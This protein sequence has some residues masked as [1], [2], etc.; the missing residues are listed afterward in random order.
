MELFSDP[1]KVDYYLET[2]SSP[3][4]QVLQELTRHT[5]LKEVHPQMLSGKVLGG[6]L[7]LF[8]K[9]ISPDRILE[10]GT[11]TG[12]SAIC[13]ARGLR[14]DGKLITIEV[15]EELRSTAL[16]YFKQAG[17]EDRIQ[18]IN[19]PALEVI[20]GLKETFDLV[21]LDAN[22]EDYLAYY[23]LALEKLAQGG[24]MLV[25]NVLWSGKV[26]EENHSDT[27]TRSLHQF[28]Q[29]VTQDVRVENLLLPIRDGLMVIKKL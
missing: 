17:L 21:F 8:S 3:E 23:H 25:D 27:T 24:Y 6:F 11:Y 9:L 12:Y 7:R 29:M 15:N 22:K 18:L 19:G 20:P 1:E 14:T 2:H 13:L 16:R 4:D 28:N 26:L 5:Y 10:I